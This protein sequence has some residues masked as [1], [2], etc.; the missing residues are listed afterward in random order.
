[1][2]AE[3]TDAASGTAPSGSADELTKTAASVD[4]AVA[5]GVTTTLGILNQTS[6]DEGT[7]MDTGSGTSWYIGTNLSF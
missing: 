2:D 5:S 4:Y 1:M 6:K 3:S 7:K